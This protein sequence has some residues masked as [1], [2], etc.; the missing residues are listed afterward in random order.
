MGGS[1]E[2]WESK[3]SPNRYYLAMKMGL[4][5]HFHGPGVARWPH[6]SDGTLL[7]GYSPISSAGFLVSAPGFDETAFDCWLQLLDLR[8]FFSTDFQPLRYAKILP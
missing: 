7:F 6:P 8:G 2:D 3:R 1:R 5:P 4:G